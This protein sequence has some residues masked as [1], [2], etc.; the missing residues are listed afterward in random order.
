MACVQSRVGFLENINIQTIIF[1]LQLFYYYIL[2]FV[3]FYFSLIA[4]NICSLTFADSKE[5]KKLDLLS[6]TKHEGHWG[7][8]KF[9]KSPG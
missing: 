3:V 4:K 9:S 6:E 5:D 8:L 1:T 2:S 7:R